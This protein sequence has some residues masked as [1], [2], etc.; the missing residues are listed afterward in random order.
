MTEVAMEV[1]E[2]LEATGTTRSE[3][4]GEVADVDADA[5]IFD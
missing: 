5:E 2:G 1:A 3:V 4:A